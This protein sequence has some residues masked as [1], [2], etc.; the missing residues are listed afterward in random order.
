M[1]ITCRRCSSLPCSRH[2]VP[3]GPRFV[4]AISH[5]NDEILA[6]KEIQ[7]FDLSNRVGVYYVRK[8][9]GTYEERQY[10]DMERLVSL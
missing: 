9:D 2:K 10:G 8:D 3:T 6:R 5:E 4:R 7:R 1:W